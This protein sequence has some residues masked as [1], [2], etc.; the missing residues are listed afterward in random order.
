M[1]DATLAFTASGTDTAYSVAVLTCAARSVGVFENSG[2]YRMSYFWKGHQQAQGWTD[3]VS[4][5]A[6]SARRWV[7]GSD[8][9]SLSAAHSFVEFSGLQRARER[10]NAVAF[11]WAAVLDLVEGDW[12]SY[13]DLVVLASG[14]EF[15][16]QFFPHLGHRFAL[17][18]DENSRE[19][20][21]GVFRCRPD[22][23]VIY[24]RDGDGFEFEGDAAQ[25][26]AYLVE[27]LRRTAHHHP[28]TVTE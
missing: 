4:S 25:T 11:Q 10:G 23:F 9:E 12:S 18:V 14:D 7:G 5:A 16:K 21:V 6:G 15:L 20:L 17:A 28:G 19:I 3:D 8:L 26:V 13:R 24:N 1:G 27:R 22:W 2:S